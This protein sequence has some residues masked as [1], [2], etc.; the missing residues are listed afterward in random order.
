MARKRSIS[1]MSPPPTAIT[2]ANVVRNSAD[3]FSSAVDHSHPFGQELAQVSE[4]AEEFGAAAI[5]DQEE[6]EMMDKGLQKFGVEDYMTE[7][8]AMFGSVFQGGYHMAASAWI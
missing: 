8:E 7:I 5:L 6:R 2:G 3:M 4:V 1:R